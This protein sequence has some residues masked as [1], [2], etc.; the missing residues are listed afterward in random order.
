[1]RT[2]S[3]WDLPYAGATVAATWT[4]FELVLDATQAG[5]DV[6]QIRIGGAF[7]HAGA[8][9]DAEHLTEQFTQKLTGLNVESAH[10]AHGGALAITIG[11]QRLDV[12]PDEQYEAWNASVPGGFMLVSLPG[13]GLA[14]WT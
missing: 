10:A 11:G 6:G 13:G 1:M 8:R 9:Y 3:G 4:G 14:E 2:A 7:E 12:P 5:V